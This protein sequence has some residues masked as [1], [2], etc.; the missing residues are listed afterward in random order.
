M[1]KQIKVVYIGQRFNGDEIVSVFIKDGKSD[2][3][4]NYLRF[5]TGRYII[6]QKY[7]AEEDGDRIQLFTK[8]L[9]VGECFTNENLLKK[10]RLESKAASA[11]KRDQSSKTR[12]DNNPL[13]EKLIEELRTEVSCLNHKDAVAFLDYLVNEVLFKPMQDEMNKRLNSIRMSG[14]RRKKI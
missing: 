14:P 2:L 3:E 11:Y 8:G 13:P 6:G 12:V 4:D 9:I 7:K 10:W 5:K 1:K